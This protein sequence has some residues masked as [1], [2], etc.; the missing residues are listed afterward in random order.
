MALNFFGLVC[1]GIRRTLLMVALT[2]MEPITH[3]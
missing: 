2:G 3:S 1:D